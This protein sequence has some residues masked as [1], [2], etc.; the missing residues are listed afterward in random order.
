MTSARVVS[1]SDTNTLPNSVNDNSRRRSTGRV[2]EWRVR[3][4]RLSAGP[5]DA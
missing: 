2:L 4:L 1:T 5:L 3:F